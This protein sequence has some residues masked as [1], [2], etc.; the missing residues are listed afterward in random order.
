MFGV[1]LSAAVF[2][3]ERRACPEMESKGSPTGRI[4]GRSLTRLNYAALRDDGLLGE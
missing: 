1:I 3:A 2:Q 4:Y